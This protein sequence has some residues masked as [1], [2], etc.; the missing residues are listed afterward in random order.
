MPNLEGRPNSFWGEGGCSSL[1]NPQQV[2]EIIRSSEFAVSVQRFSLILSMFEAISQVF[3]SAFVG[4]LMPK[5][6]AGTVQKRTS[7][8]A[9]KTAVKARFA[10]FRYVSSCKR[11]CDEQLSKHGSFLEKNNK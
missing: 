2:I 3:Y 7:L 8:L 10:K 4:P 1:S 6:A 9:I 11:C 5:A